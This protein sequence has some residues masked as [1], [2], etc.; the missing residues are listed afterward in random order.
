MKRKYSNFHRARK[1]YRKFMKL[2]KNPDLYGTTPKEHSE[3]FDRY[4]KYA[5]FAF[6][7]GINTGPSNSNHPNNQLVI[8]AHFDP[9]E[10]T[11]HLPKEI[12]YRKLTTPKGVILA[13]SYG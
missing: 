9:V 8:I 2:H 7:D 1:W 12:R 4:E 6:L 3:A 11:S 13:S 10:V 5:T